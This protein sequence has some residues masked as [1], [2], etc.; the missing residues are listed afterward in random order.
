MKN[1]FRK[2]G[3]LAGILAGILFL[4]AMLP[5]VPWMDAQAASSLTSDSIREKQSQISEMEEQQEKLKDTLTDLEQV[6]KNLETKKDNLTEYVAQLDAQMSE[7]EA[8]ISELNTQIAAKEAELE[9]T[10]AELDKAVAQEEEQYASMISRIK[11]MY[12]TGTDSIIETLI[13]A[14]SFSDFLNRA[15]YI[16]KVTTADQELFD[17]YKTTREYVELCEQQLE[18]EKEILDQSK[19]NVE[20]EQSSLDTLITQKNADITAYESDISNQEQTIEEYEAMIAS[21][22]AEIAALE[23]AV[24]EEKKAL[25]AS[26]I[27]GGDVL[28]YDGGVFKFPLASYTRVSD[29]YGWRIHP[30]LGVEQ[31]HNG[32]DFAAPAGTA[33]Y[34]AYDGQV[35]AATYSSTM[36]N[37][38]MIDHGDGL[39]TIYM[40]ASALYVSKGDVVV[41]GETIAAVGT[42]GRSTGNHL[43]FSVRKDGEYVSPWNYIS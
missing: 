37:Y 8:N 12:Q 10:Q 43:H 38:V 35:V 26:S 21:Q 5:R 6:K 40:H 30:I 16:E 36:G 34:A 39:Y 24:A 4:S 33:I 20:A 13:T 41:R 1:I 2:K 19:A 22:D 17:T 18:L 32:V 27:S 31:F 25:L 11:L 15:D 3:M 9:T 42:T 14:T 29:D 28:S 23:A 7:I